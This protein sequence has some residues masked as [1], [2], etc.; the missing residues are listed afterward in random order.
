MCYK[1][2]FAVAL[3]PL[4]NQIWAQDE[5][6][7]EGT[8]VRV[9][10]L[11]PVIQGFVHTTGVPSIVNG[12]CAPPIQ[13]YVRVPDKFLDLQKV[14]IDL[15]SGWI[16]LEIDQNDMSMRSCKS[17]TAAYARAD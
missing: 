13:V 8:C 6:G 2:R 12:V 17:Q 14:R 16:Y 7:E 5:T 4:S 10:E 3:L 11:A 1:L 9:I 15:V